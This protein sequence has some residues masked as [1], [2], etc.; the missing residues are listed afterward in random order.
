MAGR[1]TEGMH[2][3]NDLPHLVDSSRNSLTGA[4]IHLRTRYVLRTTERSRSSKDTFTGNQHQ[5]LR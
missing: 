1:Y 3:F 2:P 4:A 5:Q